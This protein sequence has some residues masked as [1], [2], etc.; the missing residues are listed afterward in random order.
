MNPPTL[1]QPILSKVA[2]HVA[3]LPV[4]VPEMREHLRIDNSGDEDVYLESLIRVAAD[5][6]SMHTRQSLTH[7]RWML[8]LDS[9]DGDA[10]ELPR[11]PLV[12]A[13]ESV[14]AGDV[15]LYCAGQRPAPDWLSVS[16]TDYLVI[17]PRQR[18]TGDAALEEVPSPVV[19]F[20]HTE[21]DG[22][23]IARKWTVT[24]STFSA[25]DANPPL[26]I[27]DEM[28]EFTDRPYSVTIEFTAGYSRDH[29]GVPP[30][31]K[32]IIKLLVAGWYVNR[33]SVGTAGGSI[34]YAVD[35]L[36]RSYDPGE[37][38]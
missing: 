8:R 13:G 31:M 18:V 20:T 1:G 35:A 6:V 29:R 19:H 16:G 23:T 24:S 26:V 25:F 11:R 4:T 17:A 12:I 22:S 10:V 32:Q 36:L 9:M 21:D 27:F 37:L 15:V 34:P 5:Y 14:Q 33:E 3:E 7:Q 30:G 2:G 28:P 38:V